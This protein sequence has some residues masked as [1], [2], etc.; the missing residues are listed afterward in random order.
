MRLL[1]V[2]VGF[3]LTV[4]FFYLRLVFVVYGQLA[5]SF[6]FTVEIRLG[7][8][9]YGAKSVRFLFIVS[10]PSPRPEIGFVFFFTVPHHN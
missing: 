3:L 8:F 9:A 1:F 4:R 10:L 5:W 6:S 2:K 7:L